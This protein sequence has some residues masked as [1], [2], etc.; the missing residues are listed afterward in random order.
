MLSGCSQAL[1][2]LYENITAREVLCINGS[3]LNSARGHVLSGSMTW[4]EA[5]LVENYFVKL[6]KNATV[7]SSCY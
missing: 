4:A 3:S 7:C 6:V 2:D 1:L 5:C